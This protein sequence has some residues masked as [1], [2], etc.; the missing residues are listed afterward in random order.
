MRFND[1]FSSAAWCVP[2]P[3]QFDQWAGTAAFRLQQ[4]TQTNLQASLLEVE[5]AKWHVFQRVQ[6]ATWL[7]P[8][9]KGHESFRL[10]LVEKRTRNRI[11]GL[12]LT[13]INYITFKKARS[14]S[15]YIEQSA[16]QV[17]TELNKIGFE[18]CLQQLTKQKEKIV[19]NLRRDEQGLSEAKK[20]LQKVK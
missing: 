2:S 18:K 6:G 12:S 10:S 4:K 9:Y 15:E 13:G 16:K 3:S 5:Q 8:L 11:N 20:T 14:N 7:H 19:D 17:T 1:S